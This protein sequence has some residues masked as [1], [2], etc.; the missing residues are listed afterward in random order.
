MAKVRGEAARRAN[1]CGACGGA[2]RAPAPVKRLVFLAMAGFAL[3]CVLAWAT[4]D[5]RS[6][7]AVWL[8]TAGVMLVAF[9]EWRDAPACVRCRMP[10]RRASAPACPGCGSAPQTWRYCRTCG[11][12]SAEVCRPNVGTWDDVAAAADLNRRQGEAI[13]GTMRELAKA[14]RSRRPRAPE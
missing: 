7:F 4:A 8:A 1:W 11:H 6:F 5:D 10:V 3:S 13:E 12:V 14:V 2:V 9:F